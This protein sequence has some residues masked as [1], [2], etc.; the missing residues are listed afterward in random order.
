MSQRNIL[1]VTSECTPFAQVGG[2]G[3]VASAL[4]AA[5]RRAGYDIRVVMPLYGEVDRDALHPIGVSLRIGL[6]D[7]V[8][9]A[10]VWQGELP[11]RVPLYLIDQ[12]DLYARS[13][14][15]GPK[16]GAFEDN[17][18]RFAWLSR[19]AC[20][21]PRHVGFAPHV[22]HANDWPTALSILFAKH[23]SQPVPTV[24][25]LHNVGYQGIAPLHDFALTGL[26]SRELSADSLEHF[27]AINL[28]KGGIL[29][30]SMLTT[31]SPTYAKEIQHPAFGCGLDGVLRSRASDLLGILNGIDDK[32]W[33]PSID[34][35]IPSPYDADNLSGKAICKSVL[36]REAGFAVRPEV[37]L[38]GLVTRLTHQ[39]GLDVLAH[40]LGRF[41]S[42]DVQM[43]LL[44]TGDAPAEAFFE[45]ASRQ[46]PDRFHAWL[47]FDPALAHRIEAGCDF[48]VMPSR[49]EPCGLNQMYSLRYGTL[50][51]VRA[52][53]GLEDSVDNYD[54]AT[55][56]GTGFKLYDLNP[57]SLLNTLA[58][59][60]STWVER[61]THI[62]TMRRRAMR[63]DFSWFRS[64]KGYET[65]Y[66]KAIAS[67]RQQR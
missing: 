60:V 22:L 43:V 64:A 15:Y 45:M 10:R 20:D 19:A 16:G 44:G 5:L 4:P 52:T 55:G 28:L 35:W 37:P 17:L 1:Y 59:A 27:G 53:G 66:E 18:L 47:G 13:G 61:R 34:P 46:R 51:I 65:V 31:V 41:L 21:L 12:P 30:A 3:D 50:P 38:F 25:T 48:F 54:E 32:A 11:E 26:P 62:E 40:A 56:Q 36:Q 57:P 23:L 39:K 24:F 67:S 8:F 6:A 7:T 9:D 42:M 2:L 14:V 33:N 63:Q 58:W 49:Y 29:G